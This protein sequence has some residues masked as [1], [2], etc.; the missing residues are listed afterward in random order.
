MNASL[1]TIRVF[2]SSKDCYLERFWRSLL[3]FDTVA[4][5]SELTCFLK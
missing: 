4:V 2:L 3:V 1:T 5:I